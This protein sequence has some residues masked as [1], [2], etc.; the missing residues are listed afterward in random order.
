MQALA[1]LIFYQRC[2]KSS[3]IRPSSHFPLAGRLQVSPPTSTQEKGHTPWQAPHPWLLLLLLLFPGSQAQS[4]A[5]VLHKEAGQTLTVRCQYPSTSSLYEMKGWCKEASAFKCIRLVTSSKPRTLA[6]I[7]R[8]SIWDDPDAGFF[9]VITTDLREEDSGH[10]WCRIYRPSDNSVS[11]SIRF[12]L[13]VSPAS[14]S[15]RTTWAPRDLVSS[16]IQTQSCVPPTEGAREAP[17]SPSAITVPS[18]PQNSTLR[19]GPAAPSALLPVLC[20][21]LG[22]KSLVLS[23]LL[24][25]WVLRNQHMPPQGRSLLHPAQRSPQAHRHFPLSH[26]TPGGQ[27][28]SNKAGLPGAPPGPLHSLQR[29]SQNSIQGLWPHPPYRAEAFLPGPLLAHPQFAL[30]PIVRAKP[31]TCSTFSPS[32]SH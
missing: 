22:A 29:K 2:W 31:N 5:H 16:Q 18:Q 7:S 30:D 10:Y 27:Q 1:F 9:T 23:T 21:L 14:A 26:R 3:K 20:G 8:F 28:V 19:P 11:K 15:T 13:V 17:E 24:V 32:L 6:S 12:Y 4:K 25:W